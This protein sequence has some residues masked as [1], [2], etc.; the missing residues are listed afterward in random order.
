MSKQLFLFFAGGGGGGA[1]AGPLLVGWSSHLFLLLV[2]LCYYVLLQSAATP[3]FKKLK[4]QLTSEQH[5]FIEESSL[6]D[7]HPVIRASLAAAGF[8]L[9]AVRVAS[10]SRGTRTRLD[11]AMS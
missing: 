8:I 1:A 10:V 11:G 7:A 2:H 6:M 3:P 5:G 9:N 4:F